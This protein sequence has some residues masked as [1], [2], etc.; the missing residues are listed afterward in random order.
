MRE[1]LARLAQDAAP[2]AEAPAHGGDGAQ[3]VLVDP[4]L[5]LGTLALGVL[6]WT[7]LAGPLRRVLLGP[8]PAP[9][10]PVAGWWM[11]ELFTVTF[12]VFVGATLAMLLTEPLG[13]WPLRGLVAT[14]LALL[15]GVALAV[16]LAR[17]VSPTGPAG[18][19]RALGF[20]AP[21][22]IGREAAYGGLALV[23][24]APLLVG[25]LLLAPWV[26]DLFGHEA[27][28]QEVLREIL[29]MTGPSLV[30]AVVLATVVGPVLEEVLFRGFVQPACVDR[31]GPAG[32]VV[33]TAVLFASIH[34]LDAFLPLTG[35]ALLLGLLRYHTAGLTAPV[36]VHCLWNGATLAVALS[37]A[38]EVP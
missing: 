25:V 30:A 13:T 4:L 29:D 37:G 1:L 32:G 18:A 27:R 26:L 15:G 2:A 5:A 20:Q 11:L 21:L 35:L 12:A 14:D 7:A 31:V 17:R 22:G 16:V 28:T 33:F 24:A 10:R 6:L 23:L 8:G 34:G 38:V 19:V 36:L 9:A 3:A